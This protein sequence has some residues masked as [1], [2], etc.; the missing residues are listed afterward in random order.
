M[1][2]GLARDAET[3]PGPVLETRG[4]SRWFA[5]LRAVDDVSL[6]VAEGKITSLIGPNGAGKTTL[7]NLVSGLL[8]PS[9]G[10]IFYRGRS[11]HRLPPHRVAHL[12]L[13]RAF[14]EPRVFPALTVLDTIRVALPGQTGEHWAAA[15]LG[16]ARLRREEEHTL[17]RG[18]EILNF[19]GLADREDE[20]AR[21]LSFG[22]QRFLAIGR[23]LAMGADLLLMDEPTVGLHGEEIRRLVTLLRHLVREQGKTLLLIEHNMDVVMELSDQVMLLV[24]GRIVASGP[25]AAIREDPT[26]VRAYLGSD[27]MV[28]A[29]G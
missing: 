1:N 28:R 9:A 19:V 18:R 16:G 25:P 6:S 24:E 27:A 17:R 3:A 7:F 12:G 26:L 23:L 15:L 22:Q 29:A 4:V 2:T 8:R 13:G 20:L 5:G 10:D 21:N 11:I 14:Q